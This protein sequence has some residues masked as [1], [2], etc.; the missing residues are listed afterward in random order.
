MS[1]VKRTSIQIPKD[2]LIKIKTMVVRQGTN[3]TPL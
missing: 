1:D 3:K 2:M